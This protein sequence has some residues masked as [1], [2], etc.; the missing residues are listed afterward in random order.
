MQSK[1]N[2]ILIAVLLIPVIYG[3]G[4]Y[5]A[6]S[7]V[8]TDA[9][10]PETFETAAAYCSGNEAARVLN[11]A[12]GQEAQLQETL[13][14]LTECTSIQL[15]A[16]R[17]VFNNALT[18]AGV[19]GVTLA[20]A[21]KDKTIIQFVDAINVNGVDVES[22]N[23]FT[24]RD[25]K[26][27]DSPKN[28]VEIRL[29]ENIHID[30][31]ITTWSITEGPERGKNGA[32]GFYPVNVANVLLENSESYYASDAG[33][34]VGQCI[35][36]VVR[37]N[38]AQFNVMGLEIENTVNAEVYD[39][40]VKNNTGGLL[41]YDLNKNT[42]VTRNIRVHRNTVINNNNDNFSNAGIVKSV[43]AG[44]GFILTA[45]RE[46]EIFENV[47]ENNNTTDIALFNG[48]ITETPDFGQ[49]AQNNFRL[50]SIYIHD[51]TF[52]GGSGD[53]IDN[54]RTNV[55]SRPLGKLM[56]SLFVLI[57]DERQSEGQGAIRVPNISY[58]GVDNGRTLLVLTNT[59][60]GNQPGN[61]NNICL[62]NNGGGKTEPALG[63]L[64][65]PALLNNSDEPTEES[66][67]AAIR[68][69]DI[70][71]YENGEGDYGGAPEA[72]FSCEGFVATG[73]P[74]NFSGGVR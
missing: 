25:L 22:A 37:N 18:I 12:P 72:G 56:E 33:I 68:A 4:I 73:V 39:N 11:F 17:F 35:N 2:K 61:H 62:K 46:V 28:A 59:M 7:E 49:W 20:G 60:F 41:V 44:V 10:Y 63:D 71:I 54:G 74:V 21:G 32:Y 29:S 34:Y 27:I 6:R 24:I 69:G 65:M 16:G 43:P 9:Q 52:N 50:H 30:N 8:R 5:I 53:A 70:V 42:I 66:M 45:A 57:N 15:A 1:F 14:S 40:V 58:D 31:V 36:A 67:R 26:I 38:L 64:N 47:F 13:N 19:N 55:E 23:S 3:V 51:N 48:L